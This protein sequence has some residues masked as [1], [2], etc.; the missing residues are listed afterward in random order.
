MHSSFPLC[1]PPC[2]HTFLLYCSCTSSEDI[3]KQSE[4]I[5]FLVLAAT[6]E[7]KNTLSFSRHFAWLPHSEHTNIK[8][9]ILFTH[10]GKEKLHSYKQT[11]L[12]Y[13][14]HVSLDHLKF[15]RFTY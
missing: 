6:D 14:I 9:L 8:Y 4:I 5:A 1:S 3:L 11:V 13:D 12:L 15:P 7:T 10:V 2:H